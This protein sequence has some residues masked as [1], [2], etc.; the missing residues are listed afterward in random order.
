[1][2]ADI[3]CV[4]SYLPIMLSDAPAYRRCDDAESLVA[5]GAP[6]IGSYSRVATLM[7]SALLG[8]RVYREPSSKSQA[9]VHRRAPGSLHGRT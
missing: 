9:N 4:P 6:L 3:P 5:T 7:A 2:L 8:S 1:V